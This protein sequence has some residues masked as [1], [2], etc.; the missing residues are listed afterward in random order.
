MA[1][2]KLKPCDKCRWDNFKE[3]LNH[4][5]EDVCLTCYAASNWENKNRGS[6]R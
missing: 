1:G 4:I 2:T 6:V 5:G 3:W